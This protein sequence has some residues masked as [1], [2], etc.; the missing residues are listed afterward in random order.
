MPDVL[1]EMFG[2][3]T[4]ERSWYA[5]VRATSPWAFSADAAPV[6][7]LIVITAGDCVMTSP[8]LDAP[9]ALTAG[10][11]V[12]VQAGVGLAL[13]DD[14]SS[15]LVRC[16]GL[17]FDDGQQTLLDGGGIATEMHTGRFSLDIDADTMMG[18]L[19]PVMRIRLD[20]QTHASIRATLALMAMELHQR[21]IG[22]GTVA[23]RLA[24]VLF[25]QVLRAWIETAEASSLGWLSALRVPQLDAAL[26]V[27]HADLSY[28]W[29]VAELAHSAAMSRS[30]FAALFK[31][32][33]GESPLSYLTRWRVYRAKMLLRST[34]LSVLEVAVEVGYESDTALS[35]AFRRVEDISPGAW[36]RMQQDADQ[37]A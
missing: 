28:P 24:D 8:A 20:D 7:R 31:S 30:S 17:T 15:P 4:I 32:V 9:L 29:T 26:R 18:S 19:P 11:C 1:D 33:T 10:D 34:S 6:A 23:G 12:I 14:L 5:G 35:R 22:V 37:A 36:R 13:L 25:I 2:R 27:L 16:D 3:M 21:S